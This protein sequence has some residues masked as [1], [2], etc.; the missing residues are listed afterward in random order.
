[1]QKYVFCLS[2][3]MRARF[4]EH[5]ISGIELVAGDQREFCISVELNRSAVV[6]NPFNAHVPVRVCQF[7]PG[8]GISANDFLPDAGE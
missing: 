1:M 7:L 8:S 6:S 2:G 3:K 4:R 5:V